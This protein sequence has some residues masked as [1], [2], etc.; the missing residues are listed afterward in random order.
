MCLVC[1]LQAV[2][3]SM[4]TVVCLEKCVVQTLQVGAE[5][6]AA[7]HVVRHLTAECIVGGFRT[8]LP[9]VNAPC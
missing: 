4:G 8:Q 5:C 9:R 7:T 3:M 2:W 1:Q 6:A